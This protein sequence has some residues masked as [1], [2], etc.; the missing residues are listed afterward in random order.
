MESYRT[1]DRSIVIPPKADMEG[2]AEAPLTSPSP[3]LAAERI[4][5][6]WGSGRTHLT[7]P[8]LT[9]WVPPSPL[10]GRRGQLARPKKGAA[11]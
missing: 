1:A 6:R 4:G 11:E 10:R 3:P 5:A 8:M 2:C 7:L 9:L